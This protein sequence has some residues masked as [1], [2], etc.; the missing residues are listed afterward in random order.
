MSVIRKKVSDLV[1]REFDR[2]VV[3]EYLGLGKH[4]KHY[5]RCTCKCGGEI[6]LPTYRVTGKTTSTKSC[7]CLRSEKLRVNRKD[8]TTHGLYR[9][10]LYAIHSGMK[11]RCHNPNSQ[12]YKY[13]GFIGISICSEWEENFMS[14]YTWAMGNGYEEGL[15]IDRL[16]STNGY[17]PENCQWVTI[18]ENSRRMNEG[19]QRRKVQENTRCKE[20][21]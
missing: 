11:Q 6:V 3:T 19:K 20:E 9:H 7:G 8:S 21:S 1:G 5:W 2:L 15:S 14:F 10:K 4:S 18:S 13:Y 17:Y 12:R 16:D